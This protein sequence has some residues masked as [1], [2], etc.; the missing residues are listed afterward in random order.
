MGF[1]NL[2]DA[3]GGIVFAG[4]VLIILGIAWACVALANFYML[5][6]IHRLYRSTGASFAKAQ[7]EFT[8]G[9]MQN[10]TVRQAAADAAR[11][12][13]RSQFANPSSQPQSQNGNR[14]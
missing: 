8:T 2:S 9:V 6:K 7:A 14:Y 12:T 10:E 3:K 5:V 1:T 11:E 4:V 13:V